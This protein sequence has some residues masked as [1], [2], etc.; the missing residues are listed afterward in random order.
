MDMFELVT[1]KNLTSYWQENPNKGPYVG[2]ALFPRKKQVGIKL[3]ELKGKGGVPIA[4]VASA[5]DTNVLYRDRIE[6]TSLSYNMPYFKEASKVSEELRQELL[7]LKPEYA[8]VVLTKIFNDQVDLID[9]AEV[10]PERMR[11]QL[12][13]TGT[14]SIV[15][16]GVNKQYNYGFDSDKQIHT[17][18]TKWDKTGADPI[19]DIEAQ[20][21]VAY[22]R[23]G[24]KIGAILLTPK[25]LNTIAK[26][27]AVVAQFAKQLNP[28]RPTSERVKEYL[29]TELNVVVLVQDKK[30][31]KARDT[32]KKEVP[33]FPDDRVALIPNAILGDTTYGTTPEEAD[34]MAQNTA[35]TSCSIV[36]TGVCVT[37]WKTLDPVNV[38]TKVSEIVLPTFPM[39]DS[40]QIVIGVTE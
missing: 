35:A 39:I 20:M 31:I 5:F 34:L 11:M 26:S 14:I 13:S 2:E 19:A 37:T 18:T 29:A 15:E 10:V 38:N 24:V 22:Q 30:Y 40:L 1:A 12:L 36:N 3:S 23:T 6:L 17:V 27:D 33:F 4:L 21:E 16:N 25:M 28:V 7:T 8:N 9:G 32:S